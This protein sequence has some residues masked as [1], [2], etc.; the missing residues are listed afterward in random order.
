VRVYSIEAA[1]SLN[2]PN[3]TNGSGR[4][5]GGQPATMLAM[6]QNEGS[7]TRRHLLRLGGVAAVGAIPIIVGGTAE[8][9]VP[10]SRRFD[11]T[12]PST[13]L[14][15]EKELANGTVMQSFGFDNP[16]GRIYTLQ[17]QQ[18]GAAGNL[19]VSELTLAGE[20]TGRYMVLQGFGHGGAIGV[21]TAGSGSA[22]YLWTEYDRVAGRTGT[23]LTR[24]RFVPGAF[25]DRSNVPDFTPYL[26]D[27]YVQS[28]RPSIDPVNNRL[29]VTFVRDGHPRVLVYSLADAVA[30]RL[31]TAHRLVEVHVPE[32]G[33]TE[34]PNCDLDL[35]DYQGFTAYGQYM[36]IYFGRYYP[37]TGDCTGDGIGNTH[38]VSYDL[39][40]ARVV[41]YRLTRA[42]Y[43]L[44]YREPEG[45]AIQIT[46]GQPRLCL[47]FAS[48]C[49]PNRR[50]AN[51]Y[52]KTT[53]I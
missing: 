12:A 38:I 41:E 50:L 39:N 13:Q 11:L 1:G 19:V 43:T 48:G 37:P 5:L 28:P 30:G 52:Y 25:Y 9:T 8:A 14:F 24:F 17:V 27:G 29:I 47:G 21:E 15:R 42:G 45:L 32:C 53:L 35:Q 36:Y 3:S 31:D 16:N 6:H 34:L 51:I 10:T 2:R 49:T 23:G 33:T 46:A 4:N 7:L 40:A 26:F 22:P 18:G 44:P 20:W